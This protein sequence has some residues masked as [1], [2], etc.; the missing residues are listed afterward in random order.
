MS[1]IFSLEYFTKKASWVRVPIFAK[2][3][4]RAISSNMSEHGEYVMSHSPGDNVKSPPSLCEEY[5]RAVPDGSS[6]I[7]AACLK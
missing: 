5:V 3:C 7:S 1:L 4:L 2:A 6:E